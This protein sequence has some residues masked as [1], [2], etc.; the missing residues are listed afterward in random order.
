[1]NGEFLVNMARLGTHLDQGRSVTSSR[2][3][4]GLP[5]SSFV[6][7]SSV[8]SESELNDGRHRAWSFISLTV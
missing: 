5:V 8:V 1:M 7:S 4:L 3:T 6:R 2:L